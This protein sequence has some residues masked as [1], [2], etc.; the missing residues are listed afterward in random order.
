MLLAASSI[1]QK[2]A[3]VEAAGVQAPRFEV[4]PLWPKP[5]PNH[6]LLGQTIGV[7]VDDKD[8][9]WVIHRAGSLEQ[10]EL[11]AT[12]NPPIAQCCAPAPPVLNYDQ[13]GNLL[14]SW[15]GRGEGYDWPESNHGIT[16]DYKGNV[17]IGGNGV[18]TPPGARGRGARGAR[19]EQV[20][21]EEQAGA[22]IGYTNDTMILKFTQAGKFLMQIGKPGQSKGSNDVE[23]LRRPAK[24]FVDKQTNE[25][26]VADGYGNHRVIVYDADTGKYK[27]HWGAY[28]NKPDDT[29]LGP[30]NPDAP[31]VQQFRNP[32]H[33]AELSVDRLLYVCDRAND[34]VQV[35]K[36]DGTFVKEGFVN[37]RTL[38]SG[39]AWDIAFSRDAQQK[40]LYLTDGENDRVHILD[41]DSLQVLT[42]FGE[43]GRQPGEFYGVH[44]IATDSKGN[45]YTGETYRGQRVQRFVFKGLG[46]V[47]KEDQGVLWPKK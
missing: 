3:A 36:P 16:I 41:R 6:W 44:S 13:E 12:T 46:P 11:H 45:I 20:Q 28:G 25:V 17:W 5:L 38:G 23:N 39:S 34:R 18:G 15:G 1:L 24:I 33:C 35:F 47:T 21:N 27:R 19:G 40:Y 31:P 22:A 32:V 42:T 30:Y 8:H 29:N 7:S 37:K 26:Y 43:G 9:I 14:A 10:G 2:R 4:D